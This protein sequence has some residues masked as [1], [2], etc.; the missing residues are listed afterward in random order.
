MKPIEE[1][2][3]ALIINSKINSGSVKVIKYVGSTPGCMTPNLWEVDKKVYSMRVFTGEIVQSD[4]LLPECML[5]RID[6]YE[7]N[8]SSE[9]KQKELVK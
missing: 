3:M 8:E 5:M 2:C 9:T 6:G 1:G 7:E 4:N